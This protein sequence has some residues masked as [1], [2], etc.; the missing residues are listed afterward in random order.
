M[1]IVTNLAGGLLGL[2]FIFFS[3]LVLL[4]MAPTPQLPEGSPAALFMGA[5]APTG[6]LT[7]VKICELMGGILVAVPGTRNF[8]LLF[9][10]PIIL[11][12]LAFHTFIAKGMGLV[13]IPLVVAALAAFLLWT[14]RKKFAG[15][16]N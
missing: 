13:G 9:L 6:Y 1:K 4:H 14:A 12:I 5:M 10:C 16:F 8:G 15:L 11:N 7:F 3:L 2:M